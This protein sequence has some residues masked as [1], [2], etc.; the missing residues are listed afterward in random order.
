[1]TEDEMVEWHHRLNGHESEQTPGI[2]DAQGSLACCS[3]WGHKKSYMTEQLNWTDT[4]ESEFSTFK[5]QNT[6]GWYFFFCFISL[7]YWGFMWDLTCLFSR[8]AFWRH[9]HLSQPLYVWS[10]HSRWPFSW[11]LYISCSTSA[12]F[13][14]T[15]LMW[16]A[17]LH[18]GS[19]QW[20]F[21]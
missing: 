12:C 19:S 2:G 15:L 11:S 17:F 18:P 10:G 4:I 1:M 6:L 9:L 5:L 8:M 3:P 20:L 13:T 21:Y 14:Y 7:L 16:R